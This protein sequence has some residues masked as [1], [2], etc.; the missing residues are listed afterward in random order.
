MK[1]KE[2]PTATTM[3]VKNTR[4]EA[5][6]SCGNADT[7]QCQYTT[8]TTVATPTYTNAVLDDSKSTLTFTGA[9]LDTYGINLICEVSVLGIVADSC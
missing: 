4:T 1:A 3:G 8:L 6:Y 9:L 2:Y 5:I 7:T